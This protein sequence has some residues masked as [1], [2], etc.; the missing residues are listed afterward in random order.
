MKARFS[1]YDPT[2]TI[3]SPDDNQPERRAPVSTSHYASALAWTWENKMLTNITKRGQTFCAPV[4][5]QPWGLVQSGLAQ[6]AVNSVNGMTGVL[7]INAGC[8]TRVYCNSNTNI[9]V[10]NQVSSIRYFITD[11]VLTVSL[12]DT[13]SLQVLPIDIAAA[14][15]AIIDDCTTGGLFPLTGGQVFDGDGFNAIIS[16][17]DCNDIQGG[18]DWAKKSRDENKQL[19]R[20]D[21][22]KL[23]RRDMVSKR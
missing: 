2:P 22:G 12:K 8:C 7:C 18:N 1:D 21:P 11:A 20:R 13:P 4:A 19:A 23:A 15:Q 9:W 14:G 17:G 10:C 3:N 16:Y 6:D 5:G